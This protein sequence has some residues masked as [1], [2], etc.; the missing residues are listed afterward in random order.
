MKNYPHLCSCSWKINLM[1]PWFPT[2]T[3]PAV[4]VLL[5]WVWKSRDFRY[6]LIWV[7]IWF[8]YEVASQIMKGSTG[9]SKNVPKKSISLGRIMG[10]WQYTV[11]KKFSNFMPILDMSIVTTSTFIISGS[12]PPAELGNHVANQSEITAKICRMAG[13]SPSM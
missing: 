5:I 2:L 6:H 8:I 10:F 12:S 7:V 9:N 4:W 3:T 11:R 13:R 1:S